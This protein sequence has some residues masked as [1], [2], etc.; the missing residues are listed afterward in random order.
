MN[1]NSFFCFAFILFSS[2]HL[3]G[4]WLISRRAHMPCRRPWT[5]ASGIGGS[6]ISAA[7]LWAA[8]ISPFCCSFFNSPFSRQEKNT[9]ERIRQQSESLEKC[10]EHR[11]LTRQGLQEIPEGDAPFPMQRFL[12]GCGCLAERD[13]T[14][15]RDGSRRN[16]LPVKCPWPCDQRS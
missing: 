4:I 13:E 11:L 10:Y 3:N 16:L 9:F 12:E 7:G 5:A 2:S 15:Q 1:K 8:S 6:V 14:G